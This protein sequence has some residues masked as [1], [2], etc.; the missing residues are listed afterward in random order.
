M[1]YPIQPE[2]LGLKPEEVV[3]AGDG[4][5][6]VTLSVAELMERY[7]IRELP[8]DGEAPLP[9]ALYYD[10]WYPYCLSGG[11]WGLYKLREQEYDGGDSDDPGVTVSFVAFAAELLREC[12]CFPSEENLTRLRRELY[13][14][15]ARRGVKHHPALK[16]YFLD[17]GSRGSYLIAGLYIRKLTSCISDGH[18]PLPHNC[19]ALLKNSGGRRLRRFL[20]ENNRA[21]G[22]AIFTGEN[23]VF[24]NPEQLTEQE[25]LALLAVH[26]GNTSF[27]SFAAEVRFHAAFLLG[28]V[29]SPVYASA[30]RADM[31]IRPREWGIICPYYR[32]NSHWVRLQKKHHPQE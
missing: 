7:G 5:R 14:V 10:D 6:A 18:L 3:S 17:P 28:P 20:E 1:G 2:E 16:A 22:K 29:E 11:V 15:T 12:L 4:F 31:A 21:S 32:K 23:L 30:L 27:H 8:G 9:C 19:R 26:T 13:R 25:R 24:S